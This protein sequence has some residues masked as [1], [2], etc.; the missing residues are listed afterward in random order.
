MVYIYLGHGKTNN[1]CTRDVIIPVPGNSDPAMDPV[2]HLNALFGCVD[3][4]PE[5]PA[6]TYADGQFI[7]Y[8]SFTST[9]KPILKKLGFNADL[10]SGHSY[11]RGGATFLHSFR[12]PVLMIQA[13]WD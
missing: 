9:L 10:Y 11:R 13:S 2:R 6:F 3:A 5:S 8:V 4:S 7:K 12:G 1:F